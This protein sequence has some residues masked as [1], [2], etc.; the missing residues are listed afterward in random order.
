MKKLIF[1]VSMILLAV[2]YAAAG[3][4]G[5]EKGMSIR[6]ITEACAG[7]RPVPSSMDGFYIIKPHKKHS[8]FENYYAKIDSDQGLNYIKAVGKSVECDVCGTE[9]RGRFEEMSG[10]LSAKYG[11]P[12]IID[13]LKESVIDPVDD[14]YWM[15][16]LRMKD[17]VLVAAWVENLPD[18]L[19]AVYLSALAEE[20]GNRAH[21]VLE[22][23]FSNNETV[24]KSEDDV[25]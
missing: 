24:V 16:T 12:V 11:K 9:I 13:T 22:Y 5:L 8:E 2:Q 17:R 14:E 23:E 6:D 25:L 15:Y 19:T 10:R 18:E 20:S 1:A 4:F 7:T 3:P 21:L